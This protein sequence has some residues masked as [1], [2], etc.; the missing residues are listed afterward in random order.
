[1][2]SFSSKPEAATVIVPPAGKAVGIKPPSG[3]Q[4][5][6]VHRVRTQ[7]S[8]AASGHGSSS[9]QGSPRLRPSS[10]HVNGH[11]VNNEGHLFG[12][13]GAGD[14]YGDADEQELQHAIAASLQES[15][16]SITLG[17]I[18]QANPSRA[19]FAKDVN[20]GSRGFSDSKKE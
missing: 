1:M 6:H 14:M 2:G 9:D 18:K 16:K 20:A 3:V 17:E 5:S 11:H 10:L 13:L 4:P 7:S 15:H 8:Q 19:N 12:E